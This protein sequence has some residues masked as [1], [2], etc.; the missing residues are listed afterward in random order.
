MDADPELHAAHDRLM[1]AVV[2][3]QGLD[4]MVQQ[5]QVAVTLPIF[6]NHKR[7]SV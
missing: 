3:A 2:V 6:K 7:Q 5:R 4:Q 1:M